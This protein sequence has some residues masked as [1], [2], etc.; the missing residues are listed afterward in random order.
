[1]YRILGADGR[2]YGPVTADQVLEW[3]KEGRAA[4]QTSARLDGE[5]EWRPL[6]SFPEFAPALAAKTATPPPPLS[7]PGSSDAETLANHIL[8]R[9]YDLRIGHCVGRSWDL[10]MSHFW[11]LLGTTFVAHFIRGVPLIGWLLA[12]VLQGGLYYLFLRLIRGQ[13]AEFSDAFRGFNQSF[14]QLFLAGLITNL[15]TSVG[16]SLCILPG[17]YLAV[18]WSF[19][20]VLV[21]DRNLEFWPA[22]ELSRKVISAHWW[23]FFGLAILC[24]LIK[25]AGVLACCIGS[26]VAA[27]VV[28]GAF[29]YA[30]EDVFGSPSAPPA[31]QV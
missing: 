11:I 18:A 12:G 5:A 26:F 9:G 21:I 13:T 30:Y 4:A 23:Q 15:L 27:P 24:L 16:Y 25:F 6:S 14:L 3:I 31:Q 17:I 19:A 28:M 2:E 7:P 22:M 1:M 8:A 29:A 10:L 20:E